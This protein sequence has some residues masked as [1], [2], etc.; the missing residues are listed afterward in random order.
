MALEPVTV[1]RHP[2]RIE[3]EDWWFAQQPQ[4]PGA[5]AVERAAADLLE[6]GE[7]VHGCG[8][9][10]DALARLEDERRAFLDAHP[11]DDLLGDVVVSAP[12][13]RLP[14]LV[15]LAAVLVLGFFLGTWATAPQDATEPGLRAKGGAILQ[16]TDAQGAPILAAA[17]D[18]VR[19]SVH[20]EIPGYPLLL[21]VQDDGASSVAYPAD[22]AAQR[23][24]PAGEALLL[25]GAAALDDYAGREEVRLYLAESP[26]TR[27][28]IADVDRKD[29]VA[30][31]VL[32][33]AR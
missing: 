30:T 23:L 1:D 25:P 9:C 14:W 11:L 21:V 17:G 24:V 32:R 27:D 31:A 12:P 28:A 29:P 7:H 26:W 19:F 16:V 6:I 13:R 22:G 3:L 2:T 10:S 18:V 20:L 8:H 33:E 5:P 4:P 15:A